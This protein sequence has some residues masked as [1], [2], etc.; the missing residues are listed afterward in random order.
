MSIFV[1]KES[2]VI[3][4]GIT[5]KEGSFFTNRMIEYGTQVV[6][7]VVPERGGSE[8]LDL[9]LFDTVR[10]AVN[11][12]DADTS[13]IFGQSPF[14]ADSMMEAADAGIKLCVCTTG[15]VPAQDMIRVKRYIR[16]IDTATPM[17]LVGPGSAGIIS[18]GEALVG[19]MPGYLYEQGNI[20][21]IARSGSLGFEAASQIRQAGLGIS[22][23]ISIGNETITGTTFTELL[24]KLEQDSQT[25]VVVMI[26][27]IGGLQEIEAAM[28][29]KDNMKKPVVGYIAGLSAPKGRRMG[30]A[31][32]I[33]SAYGES[34]E[35]KMQVL[36]ECG[37][38][39]VPDPASFVE[40]VKQVL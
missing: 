19:I 23:S 40:T 18:A 8:Y 17:S 39:V 25:S 21:I 24:A 13:I 11:D 2:R 15:H 28:Y 37:M 27:E 1:T 10:E 14:A 3:V 36:Q 30:H 26:G 12:T 22:T 32:A 33:I 7:G 4:Q 31:G 16:S 5:G 20:G 38:K 29:F 9:P 35:E 34:A 6:A